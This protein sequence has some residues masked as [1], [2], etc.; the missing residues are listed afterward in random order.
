MTSAS[1]ESFVPKLAEFLR[2]RL[3]DPPAGSYSHSVM[4]DSV[5]AR[6]K[7]MEEA[8]EVCLELGDH[9][10]HRE[11]LAEEAAYLVFHLLCGLT[12]AG[13]AWPEVEKV[14]ETRHQAPT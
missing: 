12:G 1:A 13:L 7:I 6:R 3:V 2:G 10:I 5:L 8:F 9:P 4:T 14:L 11:R